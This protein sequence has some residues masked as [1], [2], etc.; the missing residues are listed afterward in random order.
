VD[1]SSENFE[2][3]E[4]TV[5]HDIIFGSVEK[6][7]NDQPYDFVCANI[8]KSTILDLLPQVS[9]LVASPGML[10][11]SGLLENDLD[12][13]TDGLNAAGLKD[14]EIIEDNEWRTVL[15]RR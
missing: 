13:V 12:E 3:N 11:L 6:C 2:I 14:Y 9:R 4:V 8:I 15:V 5:P 1:N 10:V 7:R